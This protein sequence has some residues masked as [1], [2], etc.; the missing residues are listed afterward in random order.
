MPDDSLQDEARPD[1]AAWT[2]LTLEEA[3]WLFP[4]FAILGLVG[5]GTVGAVYRGFDAAGDRTVAIKLLPLEVSMAPG[6][7]RIFAKTLPVVSQIT[8]GHIVRVHEFGLTAQEHLFFISDFIEGSSLRE[9][10]AGG[11]LTP[12]QVFTMIEQ[13]CDAA[14]HAH[15]HGVV[16][17][18]LH[19][20]NVFIDRHGP[21][22][23]ADFGLTPFRAAVADLNGA[24]AYLAPEQVNGLH[25][26]HRA[27]VFSIG[28]MLYEALT[29]EL[30]HAD[31]APASE[32]VAVHP[33]MDAVIARAMDASPDARYHSCAELMRAI[34]AVRTLGAA[35]ARMVPAPVPA[36]LA[37]GVAPAA[38]R[39]VV[40]GTPAP[41]KH[42]HLPY[43][44]GGAVGVLA[45]IGAAYFGVKSRKKPV[46]A[47]P[48]IK[49]AEWPTTAAPAPQVQPVQT[50]SRPATPP[51][52][53]PVAPPAGEAKP[54]KAAG[55][56][57]P[58]RLEDIRMNGVTPIE[59]GGIF[60]TK[61]VRLDRIRAKDIA[62]RASIRLAEDP[63]P[64]Q[65]WLRDAAPSRIQIVLD[66]KPSCFIQTMLEA[67]KFRGFGTVTAP[68]AIVGERW[69]TV[70]FAAVGPKLFG[71]VNDR[72]VPVEMPSDV[73]ETGGIGMYS[74]GADFKDVAVMILDDL[75]PEKYPDFVKTALVASLAKSTPEAAPPPMTA[76]KAPEPPKISAEVETWLATV[77][78]PFEDRYQREVAGPFETAVAELRK[79]YVA[80]L[81][82]SAEAA[83]QAM[84]LPEALAWRA[85]RQR[86][87][88][89][90]HNVP[91]DDSD[92]P[93]AAIKP[94]RAAFRAQFAKLD[95]DRYN[96][97]R[98]IAAAYDPVLAEKQG[99]LTKNQ[100]LDDAQRLKTK[101]D[102][103]AKSWLVPPVA[104]PQPTTSSSVAGAKT[105]GAQE[106]AK[107][108]LR[109]TVAWLLAN[110]SE[111]T[112][113][114]GKA[115]NKVI[116]A[117]LL[118]LGRP[119]F[120]VRLDQAKFK[121]PPTATDLDRLAVLKEVASF[122]TNTRFPDKAYAF[123]RDLEGLDRVQLPGDNLTDAISDN[124]TSFSDLKSLQ[125]HGGTGWTGKSFGGLS[126]ATRLR[127]LSLENSGFNDE[128][129]EA[130]S[131][132]PSIEE[133][134]LQRTK[135]TDAGLVHLAK[136]RNL[137]RLGLNE[138]AVTADGLGVLKGLKN[139]ESIG[140]LTSDLPDYK[141]AVTKMST[142]F[143]RL[144]STRVRGR[145]LGKEHFEPLA[146]WRSLTH[147]AI[148]DSE[149]RAGA[150]PA[151]GTLVGLE[152]LEITNTI[153]GDIDLDE[154]KGLKSL[155]RIT[156]G[157]TKV[158]DSGLSKLKVLKNLK[159]I[160]VPNTP[161]TAE[162][163]RALEREFAGCKV[164][165]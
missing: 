57:E 41:M 3:A 163:A 33:R 24:T 112:V 16:H 118:P 97:A 62:I 50:A 36:P 65:L 93:I 8:H 70:Q 63:K 165:R 84:N 111:V 69:V 10:I 73:L 22:K 145:S 40:A 130:I 25:V 129:A 72:P 120:R 148:A 106:A 105:P 109:E 11:E 21:V 19:P 48:A 75:P 14:H 103:L 79:R 126:R 135:V 155:K 1:S 15:G 60:L 55:T 59:G 53:A 83:S 42:N 153:F 154:L 81:D 9:R 152:W 45:L 86:F 128:G 104:A 91:A 56:W 67:N 157:G 7:A 160:N 71:A 108:G 46:V 140:F 143:P 94:M 132:I 49:V 113:Y 156:L 151:I 114:D 117:R 102:E 87:F 110:G 18:A 27:D 95:A 5:Q 77:A 44:I 107:P 17:G 74:P 98:A 124:F 100:A 162:G 150:V 29:G 137:R 51:K 142:Y 134:F 133:L 80:T 99:Q 47:Q 138:T 43:W 23:V 54:A 68:W 12:M 161:V 35:G 92:N 146:A 147:L 26:D 32:R 121:T 88:D 164:T 76:P 64:A 31:S 61:S 89:S 90:G 38:A 119:A 144:I 158:T 34:V 28:V 85:E 13:V 37:V 122:E 58:V 66:G 82:R 141:D 78:K 20:G 39:S 101:R 149:L 125:I 30:P 139:L 136:L 116:D 131:K 159:E 96:R 123:L 6:M 4:Q 2:P 115:W 52:P 127:T